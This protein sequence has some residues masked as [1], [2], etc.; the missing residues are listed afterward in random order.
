MA[1]KID[2]EIAPFELSLPYESD[3]MASLIRIAAVLTSPSFQATVAGITGLPDDPHATPAF[4]ALATRG[5]MRPSALAGDLRVSAPTVSRVLEKLVVSGLVERV[6]DPSD[7][8]ASLLNLTA[9]GQQLAERLF[10]AG[11]DLMSDVLAD[12]NEA[13]RDILT[14]QLHRLAEAFA[15]R[16]FG[17]ADLPPLPEE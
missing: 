3:A 12:W 8:R 17:P 1:R 4:F 16:M 13:E 7:S 11:D 5:P 14:A 9:A 15:V 2:R 6:A 10:R